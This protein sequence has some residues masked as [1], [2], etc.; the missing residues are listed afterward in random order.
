MLFKYKALAWT[1]IDQTVG[2]FGSTAILVEAELIMIG[3]A[4]SFIHCADI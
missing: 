3:I 2:G 1:Y 4:E